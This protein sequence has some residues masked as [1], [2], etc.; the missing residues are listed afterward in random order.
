MYIALVS[1][2][3]LAELH[4]TYTMYCAREPWLSNHCW[5]V[6]LHTWWREQR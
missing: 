2:T 5:Y 6:N 3:R 4:I 1:R